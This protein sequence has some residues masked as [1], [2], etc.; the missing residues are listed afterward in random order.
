VDAHLRYESLE[1]SNLCFSP[2]ISVFISFL[3]PSSVFAAAAGNDVLLQQQVLVC[4]FAVT[5]G[6]LPY[7]PARNIRGS[8]FFG[9]DPCNVRKNHSAFEVI[10]I[11]MPALTLLESL[12]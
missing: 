10:R 9:A 11:T 7:I 3:W 5:C 2:V 1:D 6:Y 12:R 8:P 4:S